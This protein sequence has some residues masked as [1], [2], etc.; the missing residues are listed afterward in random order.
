MEPLQAIVNKVNIWTTEGV[1]GVN[2]LESITDYR[3]NEEKKYRLAT[4]N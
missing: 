2:R 3:Q 4:K 1:N